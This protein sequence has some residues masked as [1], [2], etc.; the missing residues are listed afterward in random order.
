[1]RPLAVLLT[2]A[3]EAAIL[4]G[5][6]IK[7]AVTAD[8]AELYPVRRVRRKL[9]A[10]IATLEAQ[11]AILGDSVIETALAP[12]RRELA[13][14]SG[15]SASNQ[16]LRQV[17]ILFVDVVESTAIGQRLDP[18]EIHAVMDDALERFTSIVQ[19]HHGRVLK[20]TGDGMLAVI[21]SRGSGRQQT[22]WGQSRPADCPHRTHCLK[23]GWPLG[24][25][26]G[27][28][29]QLAESD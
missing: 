15:K 12:L 17:S 11:R 6:N 1:M 26:A 10:T 23:G 3:S 18:E 20:Y 28:F 14:L 5:R 9:E 21:R 25:V 7:Q 29:A 22:F 8:R 16:Q 13:A 2:N 24:R 27:E 4:H 19:S